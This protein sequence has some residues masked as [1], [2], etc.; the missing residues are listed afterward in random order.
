MYI[1][2]A[3]PSSPAVAGPA[4][5]SAEACMYVTCVGQIESANVSHSIFSMINQ[6]M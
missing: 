5:S 4:A 3:M 6:F 2:R 1:H